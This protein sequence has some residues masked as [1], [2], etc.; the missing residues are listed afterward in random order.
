MMKWTNII[1]CCEYCFVERLFGNAGRDKDT[2]TPMHAPFE[3]NR[4]TMSV[5]TISTGFQAAWCV[6][7]L[8]VTI[9]LCLFFSPVVSIPS[10]VVPFTSIFLMQKMLGPL[11]AWWTLQ[12]KD[13][14]LAAVQQDGLKLKDVPKRFQNDREIVRE[15]VRQNVQAFELASAEWKNDQGMV[16]EAVKQNG[17]ALAFASAGGRTTGRWCA[18]P[19]CNMALGI[20][21]VGDGFLSI[22]SGEIS[23]GVR[24]EELER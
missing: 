10:F 11:S 9:P 13:G 22:M 6:V 21:I 19:L 8:S 3:R 1:R 14:A 17:L 5:F 16:R 18:R 15:A 4:L 7:A 20:K 23:R 24:L 2:G 12:F